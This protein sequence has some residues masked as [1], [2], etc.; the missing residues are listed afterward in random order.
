MSVSK[1]KINMRSQGKLEH[2]AETIFCVAYGL[3]GYPKI[4]H[5]ILIPF[6][7]TNY[8]CSLRA[9][10]SLLYGTSYNALLNKWR[11]CVHN[12]YNGKFDPAS[13]LLEH[14]PIVSEFNANSQLQYRSKLDEISQ[15]TDSNVAMRHVLGQISF[16]FL[17]PV[18]TNTLHV[19][20]PIFQL[21]S[22]FTSLNFHQ[23]VSLVLQIAH[24]IH[25]ISTHCQFRVCGQFVMDLKCHKAIIGEPVILEGTQ[26]SL[27]ASIIG[28]KT[29][30]HNYNYAR[31]VKQYICRRLAVLRNASYDPHILAPFCKLAKQFYRHSFKTTFEY[32]KTR[33]VAHNLTPANIFVAFE[34]IFF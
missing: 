5:S 23:R 9:L 15:A 29:P 13:I 6:L 33:L 26:Q 30:R 22:I 19:N 27:C 11:V 1:K 25:Q 32:S 24:C 34:G 7:M 4:T 16:T 21:S 20:V 12:Y 3:N 2:V 28:V 31:N 17:T 8:K 18:H 10:T 14:L